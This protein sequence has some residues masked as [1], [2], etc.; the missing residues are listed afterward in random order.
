MISSIFIPKKTYLTVTILSLCASAPISAFWA[1]TLN[2]QLHMRMIDRQVYFWYLESDVES[3]PEAQRTEL[4]HYL[5][6]YKKGN[7]LPVS[8][9]KVGAETSYALAA[10]R[11]YAPQLV[12]D[13]YFSP[14]VDAAGVQQRERVRTVP[15]LKSQHASSA[16]FI[17]M[18]IAW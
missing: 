14:L 1:R 3:I 4:L 15:D 18:R 9:Q 10:V 6:E 7:V 17:P 12:I 2:A 11:T 8:A 16:F 13:T 5:T